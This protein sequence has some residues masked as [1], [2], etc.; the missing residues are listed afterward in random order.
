MLL[1]KINDMANRQYNYQSS[2]NSFNIIPFLLIG[3][4]VLFVLFKVASFAFN[5]LYYLSP[6]LIIITLFIDYKVV[7]NYGKWIMN[8]IGKNPILGVVLALL[9]I[10]GYPIVGL[11]LFGKAMLKK[12]VKEMTQQFEERTQ[13]ELVEYEEVESEPQKGRI[14]LPP[15][16]KREKIKQRRNNDNEY[17]DLFDE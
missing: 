9:T 5:I 3:L 17:E 16:P 15:P 2:G 10:V 8:V 14:E 11:F 12:K 1:N 13:G 7:V 6:I 4:V